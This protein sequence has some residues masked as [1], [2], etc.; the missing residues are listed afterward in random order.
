MKSMTHVRVAAGRVRRTRR[1]GPLGERALSVRILC[2]LFA[3]WFAVAAVPA[4][5]SDTMVEPAKDVPLV[6]DVDAV[7]VGGTLAGVSV[8]ARL[9]ELGMSV[10]L[11]AP[12][13]YLGED[14]AGKL[15]LDFGPLDYKGQFGPL[16]WKITQAEGSPAFLFG[17]VSP[18]R[19]K[20]AMDELLLERNIP[21]LTWTAACDVLKDGDGAV[22]GIVVA[23]R[24]G[25]QAIR[26]KIVVDA[27]EY[28][29]VARLAGATFEPV[30]PGLATFRRTV[31]S[32]EAPQGEGVTVLSASDARTVVANLRGY[33]PHDLPTTVTGRLYVCELSLPMRDDSPRA[34]AEVEQRARDLTWTSTELDAADTLYRPPAK[35]VSLP[36]N[37]FVADAFD[38]PRL[39]VTNAVLLAERIAGMR[40]ARRAGPR[41]AASGIADAGRARSPDAPRVSAP[42]VLEAGKGIDGVLRKASG[43]MRLP[44][45]ALPVLATCD[46]FVAGLGTGGGPAAIAAARSGAKTIGVDYLYQIGGVATEGLIGKYCFGVRCGF[47]EELDA[48]VPSFGA[49]Y[50][51]AKGEWM[52][53]EIRKAGGEV[54][55]GTFVEGVVKDGDSLTGVVVVTPD[56]TR[57]VV[58]CAVAVDATGNADLAALAGEPTEFINGE[59]LSLQGAGS[60]G[61]ILGASYQNTDVGFVD[62][63]DTADLV[64]FTL[65]ARQSMGDWAWDQA[66]I[67]NSRE[68]RRMHGAYYVTAQDV[69]NARTYPDA[70]AMTC[71]NFDTHGQTVG[72]QF[73]VEDVDR[74][75][76]EKAR[77]VGSSVVFY[78]RVIYLPYRALLP[79]TTD[80]LLVVGLGMSA[81]R[82]AM[83]ILR[84]QADVQNQG[85]AAG[86]AAAMAAKAG[87]APRRIDVK[88]LQR[89]LVEKGIVPNEVLTMSDN[90]PP[91]PAA[92]ASAVERLADDYDGLAMVLW[93][94]AA[95]LPRL[96]AA[97]ARSPDDARLIYA[98]VLGILGDATGAATLVDRLAGADWDEGWNYKGMDQFGRSVSWIDTYLIALGRTRD[99]A[100]VDVLLPL[101]RKLK[102][103]DAYSHYRAV[104]LAAET[105]GDARAVP[106]L[107]ELLRRPGVS[108][109][110]IAFDAARFPYWAEYRN[111]TQRNMGTGDR[112]RSDALR[113]LCLAR[114]L[115]RLGDAADGLGRRTLEAYAADPRRAY[116]N[117]ARLVLRPRP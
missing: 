16:M 58:R 24:N 9:H 18:L 111:F 70:I 102:P 85:Y 97:Y 31:I 50:G 4:S 40:P 81:A 112:E 94:P 100:A 82:D 83:P 48:A 46:V 99:A 101:M 44:S 25:R 61:R 14:T 20:A 98:H 45:A 37:V 65:R 38:S 30:R 52:R 21:F 84:M 42:Q 11:V 15:R 57:G 88:A 35:P 55:F 41:E 32:G 6:A 62:D 59:E 115:F 66:Q 47:T 75:L 10:Y 78:E 104:A 96:R 80:G 107:V 113:E 34:R 29:T 109:H 117:H 22:A 106:A 49:V 67:V 54:W 39:T 90:F 43:T 68:R 26:A 8:A 110:A 71:S 63:T 12:R 5:A 36:P 28:G 79:Q 105:L 114:A 13:P 7:V 95:S 89:R 93:D 103:S 1:G 69:M 19:I 77:A 3:S 87:V 91:S 33:K 17:D 76:R 51:R 2:A 108:G 116:A 74:R 56:G 72:D 73:L 27:S 92:V 64:F 60:T 23:N 86:L 53:R